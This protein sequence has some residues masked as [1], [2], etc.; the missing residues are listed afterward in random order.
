MNQLLEEFTE[1]RFQNIFILK[2]KNI[3]EGDL[4]KT[5]I[6]PIF[7]AVTLAQLISTW[8]IHDLS[9]IAQILRVMCKHYS[10]DVGP[11][12]EYLPILTR[13]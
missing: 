4:A 11:W 1:L 10:E 6:H 8:T 5:G 3:T 7:G 12:I 13:Y 9:H 2:S